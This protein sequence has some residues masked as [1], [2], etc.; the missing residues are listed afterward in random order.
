VYAECLPF[1]DVPHVSRLFADF[2]YNFDRVAPFFSAPPRLAE[3]P[4]AQ[5]QRPDYDADRRRAVADVLLRQ[6]QAWNASPAALA[7]INRFRQGAHAVVTGQQVGLF[8]GPAYTLYKAVSAIK[9]AAELNGRGVSAVP[10]FWLASEDHD[11]EEVRSMTVP[12]GP[13]E[14]ATLSIA[15]FAAADAPVGSR[16]LGGDV[17]EAVAVLRSALGDAEAIDWIAEFYRPGATLADAFARLL[18]RATARFGLILIDPSDLELHRVAAPLFARVIEESEALNAALLARGHELTHAGYHEQVKVTAATS[19]LFALKDDARV[20]VRRNGSGFSIADAKVP[21]NDLARQVADAPERF[22]ANALLRPVLQDF[23]LPSVAFVA[24][25]AEIAYLAQSEV[26]Y[27]QLL[28]RATPALPRFSATLVEPRAARLLTRYKLTLRDLFG[29]AE[30]TRELLASRNLPAGLES[31]FATATQSLDKEFA[32]IQQELQQ[33]DPTLV[34]AAKRAAE[35]IGYQLTTLR[36]R[37]ARAELRR[38]EE[39]ARHADQLSTALYP[40]KDLQERVIGGIYWLA[41]YGPELL[42]RLHENATGCVDHQGIS[43]EATG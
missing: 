16:Q 27:K 29:G 38:S 35:K 8:G 34:D 39:L 33:L 26:L 2:L 21:A 7:A 1:T 6:N 17:A 4:V 40:Q 5:L 11:F 9:V 14:L 19:L 13:A 3:W 24:G 23:L 12:S 31:S 30:H 22:S 32:R 37:A 43:L 25:P 10:I 20:P 41:R 28:G 15:S 42:D 18:A 36:G